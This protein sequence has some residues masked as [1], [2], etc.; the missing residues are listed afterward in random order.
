LQIAN[1]KSFIALVPVVRR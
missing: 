1:I